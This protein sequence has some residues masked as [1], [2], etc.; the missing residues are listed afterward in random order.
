MAT[1]T[2]TASASPLQRLAQSRD[3]LLAVGVILVV[4][5]M[6][7]PLPTMLLDLLLTA[8]IALAVSILLVALFTREPLDFSVFPSVLLI[9][10]L[11]RLA[12]NVSTTRL[13]LL[14]GDAGAIIRSFGDF[15]VGGNVIV[16]L[17]IYTATLERQR[18]YGVLKAIGA[19]NRVLYQV[20]LTQALVASLAG[21]LL[22]ILLANGAVRLI[23]AARPQF[24]VVIEPADLAQALLAGL[25]MALLAAIF[26]TRVLAGLAPAEV[27]RK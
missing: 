19:K 7:I 23:M 5:M 6:V 11:F 18:E 17:I 27:F 9:V 20:V 2:A 16:G 24:L 3:V 14:N 1:R 15:V 12:L 26:P 25:G 13:I 10:T 21:A 8:N 22:G 4:G